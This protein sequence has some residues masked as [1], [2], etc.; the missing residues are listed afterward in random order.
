MHARV[1]PHTSRIHIAVHPLLRNRLPEMDVEAVE[2]VVRMRLIR[3]G[4]T[5]SLLTAESAEVEVEVEGMYIVVGLASGEPW[6]FHRRSYRQ[7]AHHDIDQRQR[8]E[9]GERTAV[10]PLGLVAEGVV[11]DSY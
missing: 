11:L 8:L 1:V 7:E 10:A 4:Q 5:S 9:V 6:C 3:A 2:G